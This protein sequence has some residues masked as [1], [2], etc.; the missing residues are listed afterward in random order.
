MV[1]IQAGCFY[2]QLHSI[3]A[4]VVLYYFLLYTFM[5]NGTAYRRMKK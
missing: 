1:V 3:H 4:V 2:S 5:I